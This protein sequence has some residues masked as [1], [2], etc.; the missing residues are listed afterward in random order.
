MRTERG[1]GGGGCICN[2]CKISSNGT[3]NDLFTFQSLTESETEKVVSLQ[4]S[5]KPCGACMCVCV[6][7]GGVGCDGRSWGQ[8]AM[9]K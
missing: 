4:Q 2:P 3:L 8:C 7:G 5:V 1:R 9:Y 6:C